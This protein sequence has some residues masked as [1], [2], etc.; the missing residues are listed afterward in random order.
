MRLE[1]PFIF[2]F[3]SVL[4]NIVC[5]TLR[6]PILDVTQSYWRCHMMLSLLPSTIIF[7]FRSH[8]FIPSSHNLT[9]I[10]E[11]FEF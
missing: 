4:L 1:R 5:R 8:S 9:V 6:G 11:V 3:Y 2:F 7:T 10:I